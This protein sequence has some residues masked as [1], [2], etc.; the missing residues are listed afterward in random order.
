MEVYKPP[1]STP[2]KLAAKSPPMQTEFTVKYTGSTVTGV[3]IRCDGSAIARWPNGSIAATI[4]HEGNEKY[5]AFA[6]Y[7]DGSLAL[8]FDKGGVGFVNYPNG[9]TM[10]ST[11]ST[12]DGLYMS[13]D[14]GS[15]LAQW[16]IQRGELDEWRSINLKLNEHLGI[17]ISIVDSFL[18]IDLFLVCN[19]IRVHLTNGYNVAMNNSDDCNHLFGKPIAPPK[20][21][22]PAKL[23]HSTLVSEIRAAAAKLN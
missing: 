11:T 14:N 23:P 4:D 12:G 6:T 16:N 8:N 19:N 1:T 2:M 15:I 13:A 3:Q 9:K 17:N 20:K 7:K 5:R 22:V 21:K 18:R 10:L